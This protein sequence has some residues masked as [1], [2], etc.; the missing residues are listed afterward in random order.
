MKLRFLGAAAAAL[1]A[2]AIGCG[3]SPTAPTSSN[4]RVMLTDTPFGDA[5]AVLITFSDVGVHASGGGW[6]TIPFGGGA[7]SRTCDLKQ[8]QTAQDVLGV[9][10]LPAGHY[11]QAR[12]TVTRV[13]LYFDYPATAGPCAPTLAA[14]SGRSVSVN[15]PSGQL[16]LNREFDVT[17]GN[18]ASMVLDFNGDQSIIQTGNGTYQISPVI[19]VVSVR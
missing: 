3:G 1:V 14:P 13:A 2:L 18:T 8:L 11:T 10:T 12:V 9:A 7:T 15:V 6:T 16:I 4:F 5:K 19:T 17:S